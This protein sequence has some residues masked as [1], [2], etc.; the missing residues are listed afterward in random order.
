MCMQLAMTLKGMNISQV[1][2]I[3]KVTKFGGF[4]L[5]LVYMYDVILLL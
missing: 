1:K 4:Q 3:L 5:L 2:H